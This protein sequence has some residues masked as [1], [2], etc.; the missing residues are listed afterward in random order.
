MIFGMKHFLRG[1]LVVLVLSGWAAA[2][3]LDVTEKE[4]GRDLVLGKGDYLVI[5]LPANPSTGYDWSYSV[6]KG[7]K[8]RQEGKVVR[9][10]RAGAKGTVGAPITELWKFK[11]LRSGSFTVTF[12]CMR[13]W[14]KGV[15]PV[16][17]VSWDVTIRR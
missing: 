10:V 4:A 14:E 7:G 1:A 9:E 16:R 13:L 12:S 2:A 6:S 8:L 15:P 17:K 3:S 11:A 5:H